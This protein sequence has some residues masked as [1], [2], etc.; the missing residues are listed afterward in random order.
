MSFFPINANII[1]S[2]LSDYFLSLLTEKAKTQAESEVLSHIQEFTLRG[3]K[4]IRASLVEIGYRLFHEKDKMDPKTLEKIHQIGIMMELLQS[5]FLIHDD[6]ID[7]APLRRGLKTLHLIWTEQFDDDLHMGE[8]MGILAGNYALIKCFEIIQNLSNITESV[9]L[10]LIRLLNR[11]VQETL[12]GQI[13]DVQVS[14]KP[15]R[16]TS[17][18]DIL[19]IMTLK[20]AKY[21]IV[22]P[23]QFGAILAN[24][25][26]RDI[27]NIGNFGVPFGLAFQISDDI[28][29]T[30]GKEEKTGKSI[31][32]DL[33]EGKKT[34]FIVDVYK[35]S[36]NDEKNRIE[37]ILGSENLSD[38]HYNQ[39][40]ELVQKYDSLGYTRKKIENF[41]KQ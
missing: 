39:I 7:K 14:F 25:S 36:N 10:A 31:N 32:S 16:K 24:A 28:I 35:K 18:Q 3:G 40:R 6:I 26:S 1:N 41:A 23:L 29:G 19:D 21:T 8:S 33:K 12:A 13:I 2:K 15:L 17:E 5:F 9:K 11:V 30:F 4:R 38:D 37:S 27:E 20:T 22:T 34:L